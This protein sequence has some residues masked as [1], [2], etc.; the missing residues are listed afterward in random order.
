MNPVLLYED[1]I[2]NL[3]KF[4]YPNIPYYNDIIDILNCFNNLIILFLDT[5]KLVYFFVTFI[6][7]SNYYA[8]ESFISYFYY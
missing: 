5:Y 8:D 6:K 1:C 2:S 3:N 7:Y 4:C